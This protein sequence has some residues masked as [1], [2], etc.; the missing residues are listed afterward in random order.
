MG[1]ECEQDIRS[2]VGQLSIFFV[3]VVALEGHKG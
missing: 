3:A 1:G 2:P